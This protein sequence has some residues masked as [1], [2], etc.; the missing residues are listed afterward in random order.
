MPVSCT[1][2]PSATSYTCVCVCGE[3]TARDLPE[4][5]QT[6][7]RKLS[8]TFGLVFMENRILVPKN[9][10][11]TVISLLH[12]GHPAINM[13]TLA[14]RH[15]WWPEMA[16]AIQKKCKTGKMSGKGIEPNLA[17]TEK[18]LPPVK[19][20]NE[21]AQLDFIG[22]ITEDH[23]RFYILLSI[24]RYGKWPAASFCQHTDDESAVK[25]LEQY[26]QLSSTPKSI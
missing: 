11:N 10:R 23:R 22:P 3:T 14:A 2:P 5:Y 26:I 6:H 16:E 12:K 1:D 8:S 21:E 9:F 4:D 15:F 13:M 25:F 17:S 24:Y 18:S 19:S 7:R 20:P